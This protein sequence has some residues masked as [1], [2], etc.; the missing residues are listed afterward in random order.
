[1][2]AQQLIIVQT[3]LTYNLAPGHAN[4]GLGGGRPC[5]KPPKTHT[6]SGAR[7]VS[8]IGSLVIAGPRRSGA[9]AVRILLAESS[10]ES[11]LRTSPSLQ[12]FSGRAYPLRRS[13]LN[14]LSCLASHAKPISAIYCGSLV[15][16]LLRQVTGPRR[17]ENRAVVLSA[18]ATIP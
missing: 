3:S 11:R 16:V 15:V 6:W 1:V 9:K 7:S 4:F 8:K 2:Q 12:A 5:P 13:A 14:Y 10:C 18:Q 17:K